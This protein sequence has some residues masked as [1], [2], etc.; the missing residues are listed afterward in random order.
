MKLRSE[1][2][3]QKSSK[4]T[5][6]IL[7]AII[8]TFLLMVG[9]IGGIFYIQNTVMKVYIDGKLVQLP[10]NIIVTDENSGKL[11]IAIKDI[12]KYLGYSAHDGEYKLYTQDMNKCYVDTKEETASF[13]LNSNKIAKVVPN[14]SSDYEYF[15]IEEPVTR[16]NEQLYTTIEG[17]QIGFNVSISYKEQNHQLEIYTLSY[18]VPYYDTI[19]KQYG[20][21]GVDQSFKNQK[22][23][24]QNLFVVQKNNLYGIVTDK[25][26]EVVSLKYKAMEFNEGQKEF[27]VTNTLG[28][29]GIITSEANTKIDLRYEDITLVD[30]ENQFYLVKSNNKYGILDGSGKTIIH[31]EYDKIG[32]DPT[33][34]NKNIVNNRI[35]NQYV[36][37]K[38]IIPVYK[39]KKWGIFDKT[40]K[41]ILPM[42]FDLLGYINSD[43]N[44]PNVDN[45][46]LLPE[47]KVIILGKEID[48]VKKYG[49]YD[50]QGNEILGLILDKAYSI[51][52]NGQTKYYMESN[53]RTYDMEQYLNQQM[54]T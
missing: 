53:G 26:E 49:I 18:L 20:Y 51:T 33:Q 36:L 7:I 3:E 19:M 4:A 15:T 25:N 27:Y 44:N 30:K 10:E 2:Q 12:A 9:V 28:E 8:I 21:T 17:I 34:F 11:Y 39:N 40:G 23:I 38:N 24:L 16:K 54:N 31:S 42:E 47:Y 6:I 35:E 37:L 50:Y 48:R 13:F 22:A 5:K 41:L 52:N 43:S 32:I 14:Q 45:L 1:G 46:F 29:K